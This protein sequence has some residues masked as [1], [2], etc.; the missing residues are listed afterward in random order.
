MR[1]IGLKLEDIAP[2]NQLERYKEKEGIQ[3]DLEW[4]WDDDD[5]NF[6]ISESKE[7]ECEKHECQ[8]M[9]DDINEFYY[10]PLC[11]K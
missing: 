2:K 10:C 7:K 5:R 9:Y 11:E 8:L 1:K 3:G 6:V 4:Y